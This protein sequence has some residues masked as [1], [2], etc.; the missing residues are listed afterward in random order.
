M[1]NAQRRS[2]RLLCLVVV[3]VGGVGTALVIAGVIPADT[4]GTMLL[5][6]SAAGAMLGLWALARPQA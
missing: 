4:D 1:T 6:L 5:P 2:T 3:L